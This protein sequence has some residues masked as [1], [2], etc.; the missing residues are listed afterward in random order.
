[1]SLQTQERHCGTVW[2]IK[3]LG[4][5]TAGEAGP[6]QSSLERGLREFRRLVV[7]LRGVPRVDSTGMG[8]LVRFAVHA[9]NR[10]GDLR[11]A[12]P[13]PFVNN[14]LQMTKLATVFRV[15][16]K[17]ED[18]ILACL[19]EQFTASD[20]KV[21]LKGRVLFIDSSPDL[22][23]FVRTLL[24]E[25]GYEVVSTSLVHDARILMQASTMDFLIFGPDSPEAPR[26]SLI[27]SLKQQRP[28]ASAFHLQSDFKH[29]D[30]HQAEATLLTMMER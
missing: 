27:S 2:V 17:E 21:P 24:K 1:M 20:A 9:R 22:C 13:N 29:Q 3:C 19:H 23:V 25:H 26:E 6:L 11:L 5:I 10:G 15:H 7:N 4:P 16:E 12:E 18:A 8:L 28:H 14:L 30:P